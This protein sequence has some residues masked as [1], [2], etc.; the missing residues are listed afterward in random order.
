MATNKHELLASITA[1]GRSRHGYY[2]I[3]DAKPVGNTLWLLLRKPDGTFTVSWERLQQDTEGGWTA[4]LYAPDMPS[5]ALTGGQ[6]FKDAVDEA[7]CAVAWQRYVERAQNYREKLAAFRS[8][9]V[10][11]DIL[12]FNG[13][14]YTLV[15]KLRSGT[16]WLVKHADTEMRLEGTNF[17]KAVKM[18]CQA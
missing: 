4:K 13:Y 18:A 6:L 17:D 1:R 12:R 15:R 14:A 9:L 16:G 3:E 2:H 7:P 5:F 11:N 8:S 10:P